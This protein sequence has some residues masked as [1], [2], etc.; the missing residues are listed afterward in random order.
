MCLGVRTYRSWFAVTC[1]SAA[2]LI[3]AVAVLAL[4]ASD[5]QAAFPGGEWSNSFHRVGDQTGRRSA[6]RILATRIHSLVEDRDGVA[7]WPWAALV[8][9]LS[10]GWLRGQRACVGAGRQAPGVYHGGFRVAAGVRQAERHRVTTH[11][12]HIAR[13]DAFACGG[14]RRVDRLVTEWSPRR[15]RRWGASDGAP[16]AVHGRPRRKRAARSHKHVRR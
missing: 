8:A 12:D 15:V 1:G 2:A 10:S 11:R 13:G 4:A 14:Q 5:A 7:Q 6:S 3:V 16:P 9:R